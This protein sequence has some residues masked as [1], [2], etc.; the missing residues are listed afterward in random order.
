MY[1]LLILIFVLP[2]RMDLF[3]LVHVLYVQYSSDELEFPI[4]SNI[5][6]ILNL[7]YST[8]RAYRAM[9]FKVYSSQ[10]TEI[11]RSYFSG[12]RGGGGVKIEKKCFGYISQTN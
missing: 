4:H 5:I 11:C 3:S 8:F 6:F 1:T 9:L 10:L 7:L 2:S 12:F